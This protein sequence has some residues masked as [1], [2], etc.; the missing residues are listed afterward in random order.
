MDSPWERCVTCQDGRSKRSKQVP[1]SKQR[2]WQWGSKGNGR[3]RGEAAYLTKSCRHSTRISFSPVNPEPCGVSGRVL[4]TP[5]ARRAFVTPTNFLTGGL[6]ERME[7]FGPL[8]GGHQ[9]DIPG[10]TFCLLMEKEVKQLGTLRSRMRRLVLEARD[11]AAWD[12]L[13]G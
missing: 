4:R 9:T 1:E 7:I 5:L 11:L 8:S 3:T 10:E 2:Q 12:A 6:M 13:Q